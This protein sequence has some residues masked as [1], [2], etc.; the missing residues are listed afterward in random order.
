MNAAEAA[1]LVVD[2]NEDNRYTLTRRLKREGYTNLTT[3]NDG[4][5]A[6]E[7][8]R[9]AAI[10][11]GAARHHDAGD[12]RLRGARAPE[13]R[14]RAA[15]S[16]GDH[17]LGGRTRWRA[18][19]AASSSAPRTT[20]P[21]PSTR[22]CLRARVGASLEKKALR[23]EVRDWNR[24]LEE[25]VQEQVA[26][27][28]RL[29]RLKGFFSPQL[30]ESIVNG[31]GEDLLKTHRREVVVVFLD[32]RG[33]TA[34]TDSSEP[35]EVMAVLG[36]YH[37]VMGQLIMAH[38]GTLE[39]FAG[40]GIMVFFNDPIPLAKP[41]ENAIGMALAMQQQFA[42]LRAA[43]TKRGF[44]LDL[45]I[46]IAQGYATL[47]AVGFEGRWEY[48]CIGSVA[49]L[50]SR[51]C[52][53]AKGGQI[54]INQKTLSRIEDVVE[55]EALGDSHAEG[56]RATGAD[57]QHHGIEGLT[58][59]PFRLW[60][61]R[62]WRA[63]A[64]NTLQ[65]VRHLV[66]AAFLC[67][68]ASVLAA[69]Q[70][71]PVVS[72]GLTNPIFV[73]HAG[74]GTHR[75]F[76]VEQGGVIR[77][78]QPGASVPAPFLDISTRVLAG[79]E[80]GLL[81]SRVPSA[82][83]DQRPVFRLS[84]PAPAMVR[85]SSPNTRVSGNPDVAEHGRDRAADHSASDPHEPQRRHAR[86]RPRRLPLHRRRRRRL[87]Q[88]PAQQRAE[89]RRAARQDPP[90]RRRSSRPDRRHALLVA[91][92]QPLRRRRR[93]ATKSSRSAGAIRG[94]SA[95]IASRGSNGWPTS[96]RARARRSTRRS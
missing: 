55:A 86:V 9:V 26:Q 76:I 31:G 78:L 95:S 7:L 3:A 58:R 19:C 14:R 49:N 47:G 54:L 88:R 16:A 82:V 91:R 56:H 2:D 90:H 11:P 23:D 20:C 35:E 85:S 39:H 87:G 57:V 51:L 53:E 74:D 42:P 67:L 41:A 34:F 45:G 62:R 38:E 29:G 44:D 69:I 72:S 46:G 28:N 64:V 8:L 12:E 77:V 37:R 59:S 68:P 89:H 30:A 17:D 61:R 94:A 22:R 93:A 6:L 1:L 48:A 18:W 4:R 21:S 70:L 65:T 84:T 10:R 80:R 25:R 96:A 52:N 66:A 71:T 24:K 50:A 81:G 33:F 75:L 79:G 40:D 43:W 15:A 92:R 73:T 63:F 27:L 32:L 83:R 36:E 5:Q 60:L 13:G